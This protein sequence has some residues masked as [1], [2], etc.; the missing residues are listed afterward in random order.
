[1]ARFTDT[2]TSFE[3]A[4]AFLAGGRDPHYRVIGHNTAVIRVTRA[5]IAIRY[6]S[7]NVITYHRD[8]RVSFRTGG[9]YSV[10][11]KDRLNA[12]SPC[13][14]WSEKGDWAID[15]YLGNGIAGDSARFEDG[16]TLG[17]DGTFQEWKAARWAIK[18]AL[19]ATPETAT[20]LAGY[21]GLA[22]GAVAPPEVA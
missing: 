15:V 20:Y 2:V 17:A 6:H 13:R 3:D 19:P 9:W 12:L 8:G 22:T 21:Y 14:V 16:V 10:T 5:A 11:T 4:E 1:M 18:H 7:T